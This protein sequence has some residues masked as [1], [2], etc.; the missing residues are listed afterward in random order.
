MLLFLKIGEIMK[1]TFLCVFACLVLLGGCS[2]KVE[3]TEKH[4]K[5]EKTITERQTL[6]AEILLQNFSHPAKLKGLIERLVYSGKHFD[7][8]AQFLEGQF[9]GKYNFNDDPY[10]ED[11][12][13]V[14]INED[15]TP[16][17]YHF[18]LDEKYSI[19]FHNS[20]FVVIEHF[21]YEYFSGAAHGLPLYNYYV[22]DA[23]EKRI[24]E[25]GE[26]IKAIPDEKIKELIAYEY[27]TDNFQRNNIW[28]PDAVKFDGTRMAL[29]W[30]VYSITP[31]ALGSIEVEV[32][33]VMGKMYLTEKGLKLLRG[34]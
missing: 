23:A 31:Y 30:N 13:P 32:D 15:G 34:K 12:F 7:D 3:I 27:D 10:N 16:Y 25:L 8:Y 17:V 29:V 26:L 14:V 28:P 19:I 1:R 6:E 4:Y 24:L 18:V 2:Q 22:I 33:D 5:Y 20:A 9:L 21:K 11:N